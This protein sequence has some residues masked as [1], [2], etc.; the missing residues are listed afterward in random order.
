MSKH[1]SGISFCALT[2]C[3]TVGLCWVLFPYAAMSRESVEAAQSPTDAEL[4]SD[5]DV[6]DFGQV[7]VLDMVLHYIDNPPVE[8]SEPAAAV[9]FQGC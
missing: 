8:S 4:F 2:L 6:K 7:P 1:L 3:A 9:R 5:V